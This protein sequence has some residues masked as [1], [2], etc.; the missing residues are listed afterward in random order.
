M[1]AEQIKRSDRIHRTRRKKQI[2]LGGIVLCLL[3]LAVLLL[4]QCRKSSAEST[5]GSAG[6]V[7][8][9][10]SIPE[11][12]AA[13]SASSVPSVDPTTDDWM[14]LPQPE[15]ALSSGSLVLVNQ[16]H[17]YD[18]AL[19]QILSVYE[20]KTDSYLV[21]DIYLSVTP[22]AME[23]LNAWMDAFS[24]ETGLSDIN[25]VAGYRSYEDQVFLY[26][27]A[28]DTKGQAHADAYLA[29]PGHSEHHTGLAVDLDT[30]DVAA[31][32]SGGFDGTGAYAWAVAHAWEYGFIQRYP[33]HKSNITGISYESWHFRYVGLPHACVM[34]EK[35]LCLEEYIDYLRGFPFSGEH[36]QVTCLGRSYEIYYCPRDQVY[37]PV[38]GTYTISGNNVDGFI[39]TIG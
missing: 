1:T 34:A 21:K 29:L 27:N 24:E 26:Q 18:P 25:I 39:V 38:N 10:A 13:E 2:L 19:P 20:N 37:V 36:L 15:A 12:T 17:A 6:S 16:S 4:T 30:Y 11:R 3:L 23:A 9:P 33:P 7:E 32:T 8:N 14:L 28:V 22:D 5:A 35:D 31:G